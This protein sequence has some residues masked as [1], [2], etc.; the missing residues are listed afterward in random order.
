[1]EELITSQ[2]ARIAPA[3]ENAGSPL[4][5]TSSQASPIVTNAE[6]TGEFPSKRM[7]EEL[8]DLYFKYFEVL[9]PIADVQ[10]LMIKIRNNVCNQFLL[11]CILSV[12]AR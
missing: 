2:P 5:S 3:P 7:I 12:A 1:M 11:Y 10:G 9:S 8:V 4:T 6:T